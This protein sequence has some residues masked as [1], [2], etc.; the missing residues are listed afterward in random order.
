MSYIKLGAVAL[1]FVSTSVFPKTTLQET[2]KKEKL[3]HS[4]LCPIKCD[5]C[6]NATQKALKFIAS[7]QKDDGSWPDFLTYAEKY[8]SG[9]TLAIFR[10][11]GTSLNGLALWAS[12]STTKEGPY[13]NHLQKALDFVMKSTTS[14]LGGFKKSIQTFQNDGL[15]CVS[16]F[17]CHANNVEKSDKIK[18]LLEKIRDRLLKNQSKDGWTYLQ[19]KQGMTFM[20][21]LVT[22][23]LVCMR[24]E[25]IEINDEI[26]Q[27]IKDFYI[28]AQNKDGGYQYFAS[29]SATGCKCNRISQ[30]GRTVG[31]GLVMYL[32]GMN[33]TETFQMTKKYVDKHYD[34]IP[35][36][37]DGASYQLLFG[38]ISLQ[39]IDQKLAEKLWYKIRDGVLKG[40]AE[41][42]SIAMKPSKDADHP[43]DE[44]PKS[45]GCYGRNY[46]TCLYAMLLQLDQK[47]LLFHKLK[48][49][50][51]KK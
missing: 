23:A 37:H 22:L 49:L 21:N 35:D 27:K 13:K 36:S 3:E 31:A 41:D 38:M 8:Y 1:L 43:I 29:G 5:P 34:Q 2:N 30:A 51:L 42:G 25:G 17:L 6:Q 20:N 48:P 40:Q 9:S 39:T 7:K 19:A 50:D 33:E 4:T 14:A 16:L 26:F 10:A 47:Y 12:G 32:M 44:D 11:A 46:A 28:K 15:A 18:D 45:T 24:S